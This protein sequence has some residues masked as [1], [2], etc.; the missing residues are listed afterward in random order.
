M[1]QFTQTFNK[2]KALS[3]AELVSKLDY[4]PKTG[5][6]TNL[7]TGKRAGSVRYRTDR[8]KS[9]PQ[10]GNRMYRRIQI[11]GISYMEQRLAWFHYTG[12]WPVEFINHINGDSLDN[13]VD[14]LR[15]AS[16]SDVA[17]N[18][19]PYRNNT[20]GFRGVTVNRDGKFVAT[21]TKFG[22]VKHLG[23]FD[24]IHEAAV[25]YRIAAKVYHGQFSTSS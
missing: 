24:N 21:I 10:S 1:T 12:S 8:E 25:A 7:R 20:S 23:T 15:P 11:N 16:A 14:N 4:N 5:H 9:N 2:E 3:H 6:F 19:G 17:S 13:R 22:E 18:C